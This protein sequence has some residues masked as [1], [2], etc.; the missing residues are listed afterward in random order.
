M[1]EL[2]AKGGEVSK[3]V[4]M[5][6]EDDDVESIFQ[7]PANKRRGVGE[8]F[9]RSSTA[10]EKL[11]Q[12]KATGQGEV[13][14]PM[15]LRA[16]ENLMLPCARNKDDVEGVESV[17]EDS[18]DVGQLPLVVEDSLEVGRLP[19]PKPLVGLDQNQMGCEVDLSQNMVQLVAKEPSRALKAPK[20]RLEESSLSEASSL[21]KSIQMVACSPQSST[22]PSIN[23][24]VDLND[25]GCRRRRRR[26]LSNL[27]QIFEESSRDVEEIAS[28]SISPANSVHTS[29]RI[30]DEVRATMAIGSQLHVNFR[31]D[32]DK[33]LTNM[34]FL[35]NKEAALLREREAAN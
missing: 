15:L 26:Q 21:E 17:V 13:G 23:L 27:I 9:R 35:E 34:I 29:Q 25:A 28:E 24:M 7:N 32:D 22:V 3:S 1:V 30:V 12:Q 16:A 6:V 10:K 18:L 8:D 5:E 2:Q 20:P 11:S 33:V 19:L 14:G 31:P 4:E